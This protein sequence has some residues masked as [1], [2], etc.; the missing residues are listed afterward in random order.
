MKN[1]ES[2][3]RPIPQLWRSYKDRQAGYRDTQIGYRDQKRKASGQIQLQAIRARPPKV[4]KRKRKMQ[5]SESVYCGA[6]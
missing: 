2:P 4:K 5:R 3:P 6:A 1:N